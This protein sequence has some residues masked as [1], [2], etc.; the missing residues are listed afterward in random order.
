MAQNLGTSL[1]RTQ[2]TKATDEQLQARMGELENIDMDE[3]TPYS[4]EVSLRREWSMIERE[5][6]SRALWNHPDAR[7][8]EA[9]GNYH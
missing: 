6:D 9:Y 2:I 8:R 1:T 7:V 3:V 4:V 5:I